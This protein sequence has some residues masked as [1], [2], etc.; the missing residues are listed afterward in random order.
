MT[1]G[2]LKRSSSVFS[3][4]QAGSPCHP[5]GISLQSVSWNPEPAA[6]SGQLLPMMQSLP[7]FDTKLVDY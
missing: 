5:L 6:E 3:L 7:V 1:S 4:D 2:V